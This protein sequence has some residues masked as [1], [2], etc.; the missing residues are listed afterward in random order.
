MKPILLI[1]HGEAEHLVED[2]VGGWTDTSLTDLGRRQAA[3]LASRLKLEVAGIPFKLYCS[4][5]KRATQTAD[6]IGRALGLIPC[7][8]PELREINNGI[9]TG[10]TREEAKRYYTEPTEPLLDWLPYPGGET[11][12]E[13]QHR[14]SGFMDRLVD[15]DR[16]LLLVAHGGTIIQVIAWWLGLDMDTLSRVSFR[17]S[18]ASISVLDVTELNERRI[19]RLND[20]AHLYSLGLSDQIRLRL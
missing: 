7:P 8:V 12:R 15:P 2:L 4:D 16:P 1:R 14:V 5:L 17:T 19:E 11:W 18:P 9:A 6:V 3:A 20:T 13:F 10:L